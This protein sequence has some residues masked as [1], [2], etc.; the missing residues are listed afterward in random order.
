MLYPP[1]RRAYSPEPVVTKDLS[2]L[3]NISSKFVGIGGS[4]PSSIQT[5]PLSPLKKPSQ[6]SN[7]S[8]QEYSW[9]KSNPKI[10]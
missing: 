10:T 6:S 1:K 9:P 4:T 2:N 8:N 3:M 7:P 5:V